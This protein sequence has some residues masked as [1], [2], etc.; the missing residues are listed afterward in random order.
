[1]QGGTEENHSCKKDAADHQF[2]KMNSE[3]KQRFEVDPK[4]R[5]EFFIQLISQL[6]GMGV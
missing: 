6:T 5:A 1:M 4:Q 2:F 3:D